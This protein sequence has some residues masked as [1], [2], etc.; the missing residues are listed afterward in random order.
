M[1]AMSAFL[2]IPALSPR[3][4]VL[5]PPL[6]DEEFERLS[7]ACECVCVERSKEGTIIVNAPAG[8]MTSDGN[9][10]INRQLR[11]WWFE[12]RRGR[13]YDCCAGF[14]LPDGSSLSPDAAYVRAEQLEGLTRKDL[15]RF[16]RL[17][18][19][20]AIELL[21]ESDSLPA[22]RKKMEAWMSNG[23]E[24]GWLVDPYARVVHVYEAGAAPLMETGSC[25]AGSGPVEGFVLDLAEVWRCYE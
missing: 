22:A 5:D 15:A 7:S 16:L 12:H 17:A 19:A 4:I 10:E 13:V 24:L 3:S 21:S 25:I 6:S 11:N 2:E 8:G 20:F 1:D 9:S 18:P 23:V 14:F